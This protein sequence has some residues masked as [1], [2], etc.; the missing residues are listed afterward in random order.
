M[1]ITYNE[2]DKEV[3][4]MLGYGIGNH[5]SLSYLTAV[6]KNITDLFPMTADQAGAIGFHQVADS[7]RSHKHCWYARFPYDLS[8]KPMHE[9]NIGRIVSTEEWAYSV[10]SKKQGDSGWTLP[11]ETA[12]EIMN[13]IIHT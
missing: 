9:S 10:R 8:D 7:S 6:V 1:D 13:R 2:E 12:A 5:L 4:V 3:V 11:D